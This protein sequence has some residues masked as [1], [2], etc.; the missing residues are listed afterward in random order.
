MRTLNIW[1][2]SAHDQPRGKSA[3]TYDFSREL[4][5]RGHQVTIFTN[6]YCH[7]THKE[8]LDNQE[9][10][11][12]EEIDGIRII[13]LR[14]I[15]YEGN[16]IKRGLN[17][18]SNV[19]RAL[20]ASKTLQD[21]PDVVIGPSVPL[22]TG[23][24]ACKIAKEKKAAFVFEVRD[25][26]PI[27]LV[28]NGALSK[29]NPIYFLFRLLEKYLYRKAQKISSVFRF[30]Q[31]HVAESGTN[32]D[33][34]TWIPNGVNLD[35]FLGFDQYQGKKTPPLTVMYVGGFAVA[36]DVITIIRT[37]A[38]LQEKKNSKFQFIIIG[39][40][41]KKAECEKEAKLNQLR[42]V[43]FREAI[44]KSEI[45]RVQMDS[46]ILIA[47]VTNSD[48]YKFGLN[49]N[50]IADYFGSSRPVIFAGDAPN[51]PIT[52]ANA[53]FT[54][55][56]ENPEELERALMKFLEMTDSQRIEMGKNG[57][58]YV[59]KELDIRNLAKRMEALLYQ[60]IRQLND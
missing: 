10:W 12:I 60:A 28:Y 49:L 29:K 18:L 6:S 50:K 44:P 8:L 27:A 17:M 2:I 14:T 34:I 53:G 3:R 42:N 23:W 26:W 58:R 4:V 9:K 59:R 31:K 24:A 39:N 51:D 25:V 20:Q 33:K 40:G 37:A 55:P 48:A 5:K 57:N 32:P 22:A 35:R 52:E 1:F 47:C 46:D 16:G 11:R 30:L 15:H 41:V 36:H 54:I 38:S 19:K 13:W 7:W 45:P 21:I 43:E 56:P